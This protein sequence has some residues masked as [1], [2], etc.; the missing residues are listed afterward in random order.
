MLLK[1]SSFPGVP[2][3]IIRNYSA[4]FA[5]YIRENGWVVTNADNMTQ[6][7]HPFKVEDCHIYVKDNTF[8]YMHTTL[9]MHKHTLL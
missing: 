2:E 4:I 3:N 6:A 5:V 8:I 9:K 1:N 7:L